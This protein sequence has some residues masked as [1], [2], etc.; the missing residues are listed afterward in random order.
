MDAGLDPTADVPAA[1]A[2]RVD[3]DVH[4]GPPQD[5]MERDST[6]SAELSPKS[7]PSAE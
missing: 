1:P 2:R 3:P 4:S 6:R 7:Q 5:T